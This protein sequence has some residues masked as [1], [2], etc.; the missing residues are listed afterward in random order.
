M[1]PGNLASQH[2][3][4]ATFI[5]SIPCCVV[6]RI[7][8]SSKYRAAY[9]DAFKVDP[10]FGD[11]V[12]DVRAADKFSGRVLRARNG[13]SVAG[14]RRKSTFSFRLRFWPDRRLRCRD[15][16]HKIHRRGEHF[17]EADFD[18]EPFR[19]FPS[20]NT[21]L[22]TN[23]NDAQL[24]V[25]L[26]VTHCRTVPLRVCIFERADRR[27]TEEPARSQRLSVFDFSGLH[28]IVDHSA[29]I[30]SKRTTDAEDKRPGETRF[31]WSVE[32]GPV[33]PQ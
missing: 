20:I 28:Q 26:R 14:D 19:F 16:R 4:S 1:K 22:K 27:S 11:I 32:I 29:L 15:R 18:A 17:P 3:E 13:I 33:R 8:I 12:N 30:S 6:K 31:G 2:T 25:E 23:A 24:A 21:T 7:G 9:L 10:G 5:R